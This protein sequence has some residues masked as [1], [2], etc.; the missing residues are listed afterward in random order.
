MRPRLPGALRSSRASLSAHSRITPGGACARGRRLE[1]ST[2]LCSR[3]RDAQICAPAFT[4]HNA[5]PA[6]PTFWWC[7]CRPMPE[8]RSSSP[9]SICLAMRYVGAPAG[10]CWCSTGRSPSASTAPA[11]AWAVRGARMRSHSQPQGRCN[12]IAPAPMLSAR[13]NGSDA[14]SLKL[15]PSTRIRAPACAEKKKLST[16]PG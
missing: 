4:V 16:D 7:Y 15:A 6:G 11:A 1:Q 10:P 14:A 13:D 8:P 3:L 2:N 12:R 5:L 9:H